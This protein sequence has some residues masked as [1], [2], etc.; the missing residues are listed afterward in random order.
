M[1]QERTPGRL[2]KIVFPGLD[3]FVYFGGPKPKPGVDVND[4]TSLVGLE[5]RREAFESII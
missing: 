1:R 2:G 4:C 5:R 3:D